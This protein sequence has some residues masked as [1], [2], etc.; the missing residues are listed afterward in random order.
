[1]LTRSLAGSRAAR[2]SAAPVGLVLATAS[3]A[4]RVFERPG[5]LR[6][7]EREL[8]LAALLSAPA[9]AWS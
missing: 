6:G 4:F 8:G 1:M 7:P 2:S 9:D 5:A 3:V